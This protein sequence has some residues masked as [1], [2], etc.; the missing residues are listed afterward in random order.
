MESGTYT[1]LLSQ[2][3][4]MKRIYTLLFSVC[5]VLTLQAQ[6]D[7]CPIDTVRGQ[8]L[9]RYTVKQGEGLYRISKNF[10]VS[11]EDIIRYNKELQT[12]GLR[13]GQVLRIPVV[14]RI[15]SSLYIVH[16]I[17]PKQTL[18]GISKQYGVRIAQLQQLNP[19]ISKNMPIGG[20]LLIGLKENVKV[21][22][23]PSEAPQQVRQEV[24]PVSAT[25]VRQDTPIAQVTIVEPLAD[26]LFVPT[27][28]K[29]SEPVR[30]AY[31]LP[32]MTNTLKRTPQIDR[33]VEF[34]EGALLAVDEKQSKQRQFE[35]Y[36][37][38]TEKSDLRIEQILSRPEMQRMDAIVGPAYPSQV[39]IVAAFADSMHIPV[40]VPFTP[41]VANLSRHP[42][43]LQFNPT[44]EREAQTF[45][46]CLQAKGDSVQ[47]LWVS[48]TDEFASSELQLV[49][50]ELSRHRVPCRNITTGILANDSLPLFLS[51]DK[52]NIL[53][54]NT[55]RFADI[56]AL[57][58]KLEIYQGR[59]SL[60]VLSR[61]AW[62]EQLSVPAYYVSVFNRPRLIDLSRLAYN[63]KR[64][65]YFRHEVTTDTPRYDWLGYDLTQ[66]LMQ[67]LSADPSLTWQE[68]IE[69]VNYKG[70]QSDLQFRQT[71]PGGGYE[72]VSIQVLTR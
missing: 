42:Y 5:F 35:I 56:I 59:Y 63:T 38:D 13:L 11:Q 49:C 24:A 66:Y 8:A 68:R 37:Y 50:H 65:Y 23:V 60:S 55:N 36:A 28:N 44:E 31:L 69:S 32:F 6:C 33:F 17:L 25:A 22:A 67:V 3:M 2:K 54:I 47:C 61:Y 51:Q 34:Y 27:E 18:Y 64:S 7:D 43:L 45:A 72:N 14:E 46:S 1:N 29:L 40:I 10:G 30:I 58:P 4:T 21:P 20:R 26:S 53:I 52:E 16:E 39:N 12:Q 41:K 15:D 19:E 48:D 62:T 9:Y 70:L 57:M 71:V